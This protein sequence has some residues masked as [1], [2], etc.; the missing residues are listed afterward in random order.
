MEKDT[1]DEDDVQI[2]LNAID[3][4]I[5]ELATTHRTK[6][7]LAGQTS[8]RVRITLSELTELVKN[9][10]E[11]L[12]GWGMGPDDFPSSDEFENDWLPVLLEQVGFSFNSDGAIEFDAEV[13]P[14]RLLH[15]R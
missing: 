1:S 5:N 10:L 13:P 14:P 8:V 15:A 11:G 4:S 12:D 9:R 2:M 6:A 7:R 3:E